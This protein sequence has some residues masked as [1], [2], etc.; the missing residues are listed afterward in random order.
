LTCYLTYGLLFPFFQTLSKLNS[1]ELIAFRLV[2]SISKTKTI[3]YLNNKGKNENKLEDFKIKWKNF[4]RSPRSHF[5]YDILSFFIFLSIF[6]YFM[7]SEF[8]FTIKNNCNL[9]LTDSSS[10]AI[11]ELEDNKR[12]I[13]N[14]LTKSANKRLTN[15]TTS[16]RD[17]IIKQPILI[18]Y[19]LDVWIFSFFV[20]EITQV[21]AKKIH[22]IINNN[23]YSIN[24][25]LKR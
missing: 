20:R 7:L 6:S 25:L 15:S 1:N 9:N 2:K 8:E 21:N 10:N 17:Y 3:G 23:F 5:I 16:C 18:E 24:Y 11:V 4:I 22:F 14:N 13:S 19:I 12:L